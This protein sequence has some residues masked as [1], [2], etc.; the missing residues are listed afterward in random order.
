MENIKEGDA[1]LHMNNINPSID[2]NNDNQYHN[3]PLDELTMQFKDSFEELV[4]LPPFRNNHNHKIQFM[5]GAN[6]VNHKPYR[7][8]VY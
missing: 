3:D 7:Y 1:Q 8:F 5:D 6:P 4:E 2:G